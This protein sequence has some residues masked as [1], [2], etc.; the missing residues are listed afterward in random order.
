MRKDPLFWRVLDLDLDSIIH[1]LNWQQRDEVEGVI[2][3]W[4][5]LPLEIAEV[6]RSPRSWRLVCLSLDNRQPREPPSR[7][8]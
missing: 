4:L 5:G 6:F 7:Y 2:K 8:G 1:F 3:F